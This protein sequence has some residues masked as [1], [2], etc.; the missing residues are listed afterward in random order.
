[1]NK[2][3]C[4]EKLNYVRDT[5]YFSLG[6]Y[7]L[8]T[9]DLTKDS[10]CDYCIKVDDSNVYVFKKEEV[11]PKGEPLSQQISFSQSLETGHA[12]QFVRQ[13]FLYMIQDTFESAKSYAN[14]SGKFQD[15]K[16]QPW[17][18]F[19]RHLRNAIGHNGTW[20][21]QDTSDLPTTFRNK[22]ITSEMNGQ[23]LGDFV[24]WFYGLQLC[25]N[26]ITWVNKN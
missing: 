11:P 18:S 24:G 22:T 7:G 17:Y 23:A 25:S 16:A 14:Q 5:F 4:Q 9:N 15:F 3:Q 26:I 13:T 2:A 19:A 1:M 10:L 21:I 20:N 12:L 8:A 6:G